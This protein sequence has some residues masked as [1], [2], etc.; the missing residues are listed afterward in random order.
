MYATFHVVS[1]SW[2]NQDNALHEMNKKASS[3]ITSSSLHRKSVFFQT[4]SWL[5]SWGGGVPLTNG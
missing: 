3:E 5:E 4:A 1:E 2:P